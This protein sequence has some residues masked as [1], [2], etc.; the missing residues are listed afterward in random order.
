VKGSSCLGGAVHCVQ[1]DSADSGTCVR[2][3]TA[4]QCVATK[5]ATKVRTKYP[6]NFPPRLLGFSGVHARSRHDCCDSVTFVGPQLSVDRRF[7]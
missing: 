3:S 1:D 6:F 5:V 4:A 7:T 2:R